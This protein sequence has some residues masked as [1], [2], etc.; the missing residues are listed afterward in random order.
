MGRTRGRT[1]SAPETFCPCLA[2]KEV[3]R[4]RHELLSRNLPI[5]HRAYELIVAATAQAHDLTVV[6]SNTRDYQD[7]P[8][9]KRPN[10]RQQ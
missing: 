10:P 4:L 9:L 8:G 3:V 5:K 6:T 7:I 2:S 1:S